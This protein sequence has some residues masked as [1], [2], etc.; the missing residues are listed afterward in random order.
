LLAGVEEKK[1]GKK[2][3]KKLKGRKRETRSGRIWEYEVVGKK[4]DQET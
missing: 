2:K 1:C 4:S 3:K